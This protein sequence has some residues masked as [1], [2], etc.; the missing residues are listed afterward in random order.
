MAQLRREE[1]SNLIYILRHSQFCAIFKIILMKTLR[2]LRKEK[3][4]SIILF[5][6]I[7]VQC[8]KSWPVLILKCKT[9]IKLLHTFGKT[10]QRPRSERNAED[11]IK[12]QKKCE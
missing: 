4:G 3:K 9:K 12:E 10:L 5:S 8:S 11:S 2:K 6:Y 1:K 7:K